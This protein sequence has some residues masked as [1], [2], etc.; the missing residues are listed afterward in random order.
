M[1]GAGREMDVDA[2]HTFGQRQRRIEREPPYV[3]GLGGLFIQRLK[4]SVYR[5]TDNVEHHFLSSRSDA[6]ISLER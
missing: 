5:I 3:F 4:F 1:I 2:R 6:A